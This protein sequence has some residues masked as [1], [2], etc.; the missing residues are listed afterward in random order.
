MHRL[1]VAIRPPASIREQLLDVM[2]GVL[3][4]R[5]Q[6]DEQLHLT[7][8]FIGDVERHQAEDIAS[9]LGAIRHPSFDIRLSGIGSFA[10]RGKGSLWAGLAPTDQ[11]HALHA[12][13]DQACKRAGVAPDT[14]A[15]HPHI[16]I[17]RIGR[18][19][20]ALEPFLL[21]WS[22]LSS[23]AFQAD[24]FR[25]YESHLG[26]TGATYETIAR[27]PLLDVQAPSCSSNR[28]TSPP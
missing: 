14:R 21:R 23:P 8:R 18:D 28:S 3:S 16:T 19:T 5:W 11:L 24:D 27:Y 22:A 17:A 4:A 1:F 12:K 2:E 13:V 20:A 6:E 9:A 10:K 26:S 7:L 15:Y 25:L